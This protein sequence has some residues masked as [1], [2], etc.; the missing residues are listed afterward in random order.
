MRTMTN[1][2]KVGT[3][4]ALG[5]LLSSTTALAQTTLAPL[6]QGDDEEY[7]IDPITVGA[8]RVTPQVLA[9][10]TYDNN[11]FADPDGSELEDVE[12]ILRPE[13]NVQTGNDNLRFDLDVYGEFSRF[14][15]LSSENSEAYGAAGRFTYGPSAT[16]ALSVEAGFARLVEDRSD[17][18][19]RNLIGPGPRLI[20]STYANASYNRTGGRTL[21]SLTA[22]YRN[23]DAVSSIAD[24]RDFETFTGTATVGYR[25]SGPL[26]ATVT[27]FASARDFRLEDTLSG[28]SRDSKTYGAQLGVSFV[29]SERFRGRARLGLF[30]F[31]PSNPV[32]DERTGFSADVSLIYLPTRRIAVILDA[33]NG[34]VA[35]FRG[36]AQARTDT[37]VSA[38]GQF[39]IRH[40]LYGRTGVGWSRN[41][42]IGSGIEQR[43]LSSNIAVEY[44]ARR[45]LSL[46]AQLEVADRSSDDPTEEFDKFR[47]TLAARIRF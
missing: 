30:R 38:T 2:N 25:V 3:A 28:A 36:G 32:A 34:D 29:E 15:D 44:L 12:F 17:P 27:A 20:D 18:E 1:R 23:L 24:D 41:R 45:R 47:A 16:D 42:F 10:A 8:L 19:A 46:I 13:L 40:N 26:F 22:G 21:L 43:T 37:R 39:E 7:E 31:D 14:A 11:V 6:I 35:T 33:F 4:F 9:E 5:M